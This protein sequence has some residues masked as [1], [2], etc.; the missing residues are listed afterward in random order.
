MIE[1]GHGLGFAAEAVAELCMGDL[2]GHVAA[3]GGIVSLINLPHATL[4]EGQ[5]FVTSD[6]LTRRQGH[7]GDCSVGD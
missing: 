1:R 6:L 7:C 2:D 4:G 3:S 5:Y